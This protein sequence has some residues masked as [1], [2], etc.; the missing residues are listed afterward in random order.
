M[1]NLSLILIAS[2]LIFTGLPMRAQEKE[3]QEPQYLFPAGSGKIHVSGFGAYTIG[4]SQFDNNFAVYNGGG[5]AVLLNQTIYLGGYGTGLS[6]QHRYGDL[7]LK[8]DQGEVITYR[9][10]YTQ[11][12]H[13][14]FWL[15]YLHQS[16]KAIHFGISTKLGWG[17]VSLSDNYYKGE[18][19]DHY[20][21]LVNDRVFVVT[22]Q[23]EV[24][25][26]LFKWFKINTGVG[27]QFVTGVDYT[28]ITPDNGIKKFF[29]SKDFNQPMVNL[30]F[31]FGGFGG[32]R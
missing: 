20:Y 21:S 17:S 7:T 26:N 32:K 4:F 22:P 11:F 15:G 9:D 1:K 30:S 27:Y 13:G 16:Y 19:D 28:Y 18:Q 25:F 5:G 31:V 10:L 24:E 2:L 3:S 23:L 29:D 8:N 14:G 12:G 6:T